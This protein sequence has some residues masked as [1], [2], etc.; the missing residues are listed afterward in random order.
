MNQEDFETERRRRIEIVQGCGGVLPH[1]E[2]FYIHS[3]QYA[4]S[5]SYEA[6]LRYDGYLAS[7]ADAST[8]VSTVHGALSHAAALSRFFWP[9][10]SKGLASSRGETLRNRFDVTDQSP[11]HEHEMRNALEHLDARLDEY[12][13]WNDAG[14]FF[15]GA[16][17]DNHELAD[18]PVGR[19]FKLVDPKHQVFVVLGQK[20]DFRPVR[21]E[22]KRILERTEAEGA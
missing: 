11:L 4:A 17:V 6:F 12:L 14:Y 18:D 10:R 20:F 22:V 1:C 3:V 19:I 8:I 5:R 2:A 16:M 15:P 13:L 7:S 9:S 21:A